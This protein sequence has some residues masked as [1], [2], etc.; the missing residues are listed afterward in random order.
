V[1]RSAAPAAAP[2]TALLARLLADLPPG[3]TEIYFHP[4]TRRC[5]ELDRTM[6]DYEHERELETLTS[7]VLRDAVIASGAELRSLGSL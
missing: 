1:G 2:R 4:A 7:A 6:P 5:P 3:T